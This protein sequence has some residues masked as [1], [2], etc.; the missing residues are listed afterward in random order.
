MRLEIEQ[1]RAVAALLAA[2]GDVVDAQHALCDW[3]R[4]TQPQNQRFC[5]LTIRKRLRARGEF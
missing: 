2:Q 5:C 1:E 3:M 4:S